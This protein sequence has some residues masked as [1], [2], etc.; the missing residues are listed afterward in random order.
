[1]IKPGAQQRAEQVMLT[2]HARP[3]GSSLSGLGTGAGGDAWRGIEPTFVPLMPLWWRD[4]RVEGVNVR[5]LHDGTQVAI[6]L[7]WDDATADDLADRPQSFSDGAA[8]QFGAAPNPPLFAMGAAGSPPV[9]I[10]YWKASRQRDLTQ[11]H[12]SLDATYPNAASDAYEPWIGSDDIF[13]TASSVGNPVS[14]GVIRS[15]E[16]ELRAGGIGTLTALLGVTMRAAGTGERTET[17]WRVTFL[18]PLGPAPGGDGAA[19]TLAP[20]ASSS[21]ALAVWEGSAGDRNGQKSVTIWHRLVLD[22]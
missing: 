1:M 2:L 11:E 15:A 14:P 16:E 7:S 12:A 3:A 18:Y 10:W 9:T 5:A 20:G 17:G 4:E 8:I 6:E 21:I 22:P 19:V 13:N